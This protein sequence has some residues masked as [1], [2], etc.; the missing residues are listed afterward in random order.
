MTPKRRFS[1]NR[2][3]F[4]R[5]GSGFCSLRVIFLGL[6][7]A[8]SWKRVQREVFGGEKFTCFECVNG[9]LGNFTENRGWWN[10]GASLGHSPG[11]ESLLCAPSCGRGGWQAAG[12]HGERC[13]ADQAGRRRGRRGGRGRCVGA[14][15]EG[16]ERKK[17]KGTMIVP[18]DP[19]G[20]LP[21]V[22]VGSGRVFWGISES[23]G[24]GGGVLSR[25]LAWAGKI[26]LGFRR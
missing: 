24:G 14:G 2:T 21:V 4:S 1:V 15:G 26:R 8:T 12:R 9:K 7:H 13:L 10:P 3:A 17:S 25:R 20:F 6:C 22:V 11:L 18:L 16:R 5:E 23:C 19:C